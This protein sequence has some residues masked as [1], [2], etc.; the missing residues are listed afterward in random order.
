MTPC[1]RRRRRA[2]PAP[3][4][5]GAG[6][7]RLS[8]RRSQVVRHEGLGVGSVS[9]RARAGT[10]SSRQGPAPRRSSALQVAGGSGPAAT[11]AVRATQGRGGAAA[12]CGSRVMA[13]CSMHTPSGREC[14]V[15]LS[16]TITART[17][18]PPTC[19]TR[20]HLR[21]QTAPRRRAGMRC[22][23]RCQKCVTTQERPYPQHIIY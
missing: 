7:A 21:T 19:H 13:T 2:P 18:S 9:A 10:W 6:A 12:G 4:D 20:R 3:R 11:V 1:H 14:I 22:C 8:P 23:L 17:S 5:G 15:L 16:V